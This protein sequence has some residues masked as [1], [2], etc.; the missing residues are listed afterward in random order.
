MDPGNVIGEPTAALLTKT[1][2]SQP[3]ELPSPSGS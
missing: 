2:I 1:R 3:F